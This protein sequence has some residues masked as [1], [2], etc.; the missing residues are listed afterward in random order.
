MEAQEV[1]VS[2]IITTHN[3]CDLLK[4]AIESAVNQSYS[5]KE[6]IVVDDAS[7]DGTP[8]VVAA[9][10]T[11]KY[12]HINPSES[13]GGNHARNVGL[14]SAIGDYVAFLDDDDFWQPDK[15]EIQATEAER[16][17]AGVVI[18][19]MTREVINS[20]GTTHLAKD[21]VTHT[22]VQD[23]SR[24]IF[25]GVPTVTSCILLKRDTLL[26]VGCFDE[27]LTSWQEYELLIRLAQTTSFSI[28]NDNLVVYRQN[29]KDCRR[30]SNNYFKW[31][32][33]VRLIE[34]KHHAL[35]SSLPFLYRL[36]WNIVKL[37]DGTGRAR[38]AGLPVRSAIFRA[39]N[40]M[41]RAIC[42]VIFI[43]GYHPTPAPSATA[44]RN[45]R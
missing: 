29:V 36:R 34:K 15:L 31:R 21:D 41:L 9:F 35:I 12:I 16:S 40:I 3:R 24:N 33:S 26:K 32:N 17:G 13:K 1:T 30:I 23:M 11:V 38:N 4:R 10:P 43:F 18:C 6:V 7:T 8:T 25:C 45:G 22:G 5:S 44:Q 42:K 14:A 39:A 20:D 27:S 37:T 28:I 19:S 2:A